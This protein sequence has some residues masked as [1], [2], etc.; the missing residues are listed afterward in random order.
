MKS[1]EPLKPGQKVLVQCPKTSRWSIPGTIKTRRGKRSYLVDTNSGGQ[2]LRNR[3]FLRPNPGPGPISHGP[4]PTSHGP[5]PTSNHVS[6]DSTNT[7]SPTGPS[8]KQHDLRP[9]KVTF[10]DFKL[11]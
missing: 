4:G 6:M 10:K 11:K 7:P 5:G 1:V 3:R 8:Q 9:R 2:F